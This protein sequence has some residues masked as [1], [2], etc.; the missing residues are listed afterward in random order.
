MKGLG[1]ALTQEPETRRFRLQ[2][3]DECRGKVHRHRKGLIS[4]AF[5]K[6]PWE[7]GFTN[8]TTTL[9]YPRTIYWKP[10]RMSQVS[11]PEVKHDKVKVKVKV[12]DTSLLC[13]PWWPSAPLTC[14]V[15]IGASNTRQPSKKDS[16]G[17]FKWTSHLKAYQKT[18]IYPPLLGMKSPHRQTP[19]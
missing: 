17:P 9:H 4:R 6:F 10:S 1:A 11:P 12:P 16:K 2:S 18:T 5:Q 19:S 8:I 7:T 13:D 3:P 15:T 14:R